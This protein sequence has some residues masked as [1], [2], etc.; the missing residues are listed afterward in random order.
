[1]RVCYWDKELSCFAGKET[2]VTIGSFDG[3]HK[4]HRVLIDTLTRICAEKNY[5]SVV[6]TFTRP[7]PAIK[8]AGDYAGDICSLSQRLALFE[9]LHID[10]LILVDFDEKF[11]TVSGTDFLLQLAERINMRCL[12]EGFDFHC[13]YKG[14][15]TRTE[16]ERWA[17][18]SQVETHFL[19]PVYYTA[20]DGKRE[21]VSSSFIRRMILNG[22]FSAA[23][24]LLGHPYELDIEEIRRVSA[25]GLP[26]TQLLPPDGVYCAFSETDSTIM[27]EVKNGTIADLPDCR[28]VRFNVKN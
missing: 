2:A 5:Q 17:K 15:T 23:A 7:L 1:M 6:F 12:V 21:R 11:A 14:K 25:A 9:Q 16:I 13:G 27:L 19:E 20:A 22:N 4:G 26:V 18:G 10:T 28:R 8:H 24:E 3:M